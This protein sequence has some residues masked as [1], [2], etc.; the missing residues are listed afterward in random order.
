MHRA[1]ISRDA[2]PIGVEPDGAK[3][4][5]H[6]VIKCRGRQRA[7]CTREL[8][9]ARS[10]RFLWNCPRADTLL[11]RD[12]S[13]SPAVDLHPQTMNGTGSHDHGPEVPASLC[14]ICDHL[15]SPRIRP[16]VAWHLQQIVLMKVSVS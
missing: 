9:S 11:A 14:P 5:F 10:S 16:G 13:V 3:L 15:T 1:A 2:A 6:G 8:S 12:Q 4:V 7:K